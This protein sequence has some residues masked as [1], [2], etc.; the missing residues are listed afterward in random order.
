[1]VKRLT[2]ANVAHST[3]LDRVR[4]ENDR[5]QRQLARSRGSSSS[6]G[7]GKRAPIGSIASASFAGGS[8]PLPPPPPMM[9]TMDDDIN[10]IATPYTV[11]T[12]LHDYG[13]DE[14]A[15]LIEI[16]PLGG[17]VVPVAVQEVRGDG[18]DTVGEDDMMGRPRWG[19][20]TMRRTR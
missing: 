20:D 3:D 6:G 13:G 9:T 17:D 12:Q 4:R 18:Q 1:M 10:T 16:R 15:A 14:S 2:N 19:D 5:L 11:G 8:Q 7:N